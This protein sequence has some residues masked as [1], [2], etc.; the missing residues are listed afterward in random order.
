MSNILKLLVPL[1]KQQI[2]AGLDV[3]V[4]TPGR[5]HDFA[6]KGTL[7]LGALDHVVLDEVDQMLDMGFSEIVEQILSFAYSEE[8]KETNPQT[9]LFSATLPVWVYKTAK[10]YMRDSLKKV[11]LI[12]QQLVR[13]ATTVQHLAIRSSYHDRAS[14]IGDVIQVY[15]GNHGRTIVFCATKKDADELAMSD[16]IKQVANVLHGDI[17]QD[18]REMVLKSFREGRCKVMIATDVAARGLDIPEVDLVIQCNPPKDTDSYIHRSGRTGRAGRQGTCVCFYK[19]QEEGALRMVEHH[20][21]IRFKRIGAPAPQEIIKAVAEDAIRSLDGV[22][23]DVLKLFEESAKKLIEEKGAVPALAT[24]LAVMSG[25]TQVKARSL[26]SSAEG[27]TTYHFKT[28]M[29][30][31]GLGYCWRSLE[32]CLEEDVREKI[33]RMRFTADKMGSVFDIPSELESIIENHWSDGRYDTLEKATSLPE[34]LESSSRDSG[35][36]GGRGRGRGFGSGGGFRGRGGG[37]G[38][39]GGGGGSGGYRGGGGGYGKTSGGSNNQ[40][41]YFD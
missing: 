19:H 2:R 20:T 23:D 28:N 40:K 24:A 8:S 18:K 37:R 29:V 9:C 13:T 25:S 32:R 39:Y 1:A 10:K 15:S 31:N 7:N 16:A 22:S 41:V 12:G 4:G 38:R 5:T 14:T 35:R 34:L 11:D 26:L 27:F 6:Q 3:I 17:P 30:M 36:G 33:Q 21:G